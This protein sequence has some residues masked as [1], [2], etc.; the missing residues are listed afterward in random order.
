MGVAIRWLAEHA[1]GRAQRDVVVTVNGI[2]GR[3]AFQQPGHV[4]QE[5]RVVLV[6]DDSGRRVQRLDVEQPRLYGGRRYE[7]FKIGREVDELRG[8]FGIDADSRVATGLTLGNGLH[9]NPPR[10]GSVSGPRQVLSGR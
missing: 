6:D 4:R 7:G 1:I 2:H 10:G 8:V 3:Q 5:E 9:G